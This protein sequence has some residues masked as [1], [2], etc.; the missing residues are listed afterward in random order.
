M[1]NQFILYISILFLSV[2]CTQQQRDSITPLPTAIGK[3]GQLLVVS[4]N[5][6][7]EGLPGEAMRDY[8]LQAFPVLPQPEPIF[9][10]KYVEAMNLARLQQEWR[11]IIFLAD[12]SQKT[13]STKE[14]TKV[15]GK[16]GVERAKIDFDYNTAVVENMW[17]D[18]Q[19]IIY[20]FAPNKAQLLENIK[21]KE[22][23]I[24]KRIKAADDKKIRANTYQS[25]I[26]RSLVNEIKDKFGVAM[27]VPGTYRSA[28]MDSVKK[29]M[30]IRRETGTISSNIL[31]RVSDY[32]KN[33]QLNEASIIA[34]RDSLG[35]RMITSA[36]KGSYM[37][38]DQVN[39][40]IQYQK[41]SINGLYA[42]E[43]RG[44]WNMKNDF[45]GGPFLSYMIYNPDSQ[46]V[47]FIDGFVHAP[48][49]D[50]RSLV[51]QL[52]VIIQ[53]LKF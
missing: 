46:K 6:I 26:N 11:V 1:R 29:E 22:Q 42:L 19:I 7:W 41:T 9:D 43:A 33:T 48:G 28:V 21:K 14:V 35:K 3:A 5:A 45:M 17:A 39:I 37:A 23:S 30:W 18:G 13:K 8:L 47:V 12:L 20:L 15:I 4:E 10:V 31:L 34:I 53:S 32:D 25:G 49:E 40:P 52:E 36:A 51:Q 16:E 38:S 27:N 2:A 44:L 24:I 50:K